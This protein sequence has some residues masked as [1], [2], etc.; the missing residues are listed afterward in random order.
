MNKEY[1]VHMWKYHN[2]TH[3]VL[4]KITSKRREVEGIKNYGNKQ[5]TKCANIIYQI[6]L[7]TKQS[8][9]V[10]ANMLQQYYRQIVAIPHI[11]KS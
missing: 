1:C 9:D 7:E 6:H 4:M 3:Y 11:S 8:E 10:Q 5:K 2:K